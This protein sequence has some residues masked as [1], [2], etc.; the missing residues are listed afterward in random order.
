[1]AI[2]CRIRAQFG[3][4]SLAN[5]VHGSANQEE[6]DKNISLIF[7][8]L[9]ITPDGRVKGSLPWTPILVKV[10]NSVSVFIKWCMSIRGGL[11]LRRGLI[12]IVNLLI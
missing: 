6:A 7:G 3:H 9:D 4:N 11:L 5:A 10:I 1:M 8:D 12:S 2:S